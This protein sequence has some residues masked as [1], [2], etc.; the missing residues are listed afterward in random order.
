[1]RVYPTHGTEQ[2]RALAVLAAVAAVA[3]AVSR[4]PRPTQR[5]SADG[6]PVSGGDS[7][8]GRRQRQHSRRSCRNGG[9]RRGRAGPFRAAPERHG[10][11]RRRQRL[12]PLRG[13]R[14]GR[15][16]DR[17]QLS[18]AATSSRAAGR[19]GCPSQK[20]C[21]R[22]FVV[23][24]ASMTPSVRVST[25]MDTCLPANSASLG[26]DG[27]GHVWGSGSGVIRALNRRHPVGGHF[28][29]H[30]ADGG[31]GACSPASI[32]PQ[33]LHHAWSSCSDAL[34]NC[35]CLLGRCRGRRREV[36]GARDRRELHGLVAEQGVAGA[37][38]RGVSQ[39]DHVPGQASS[40]R[41]ALLAE[42]RL[43]VLGDERLAGGG[44][45]QH[46]AALERC[47]K[48]TRA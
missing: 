38:R 46:V 28:E 39:A 19:W 33:H 10:R 32:G 31:T 37:Q 3:I 41:G 5:A 27:P 18:P 48:R 47:R 20:P 23:N 34:R 12:H 11:P 13:V 4:R 9:T 40:R 8:S 24:S 30:G 15:A 7:R 14:A 2:A 22:H 35:L 36:L 26:V 29:L 16:L 1:M 21:R 45:G 17:A 25:S 42:H 6:N 43:R 44:V